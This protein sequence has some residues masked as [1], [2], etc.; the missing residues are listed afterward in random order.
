MGT[1]KTREH[2]LT[3]IDGARSPASIPRRSPDLILHNGSIVTVDASFTTAS[4]VAVSGGIIT[5]VGSDGDIL[6]TAGPATQ[7]IDLAGKTVLPGINDA[8]L[9]GVNLGLTYP[10][11]CVPLAFPEVQ[12]IAD[13]VARVEQAAKS[14][15]PGQW[16][17]GRGWDTAYLREC[18]ETNREPSRHDL[19][20]VSPDHPVYL[21]DFSGHAAWVNTLALK[22]ANVDST[23]VP[24]VGGVIEHDAAGHPTGILREAA[25]VLVRDARPAPDSRQLA[26]AVRTALE[27][28]RSIGITSYTEPGLDAASIATYSALLESGELTSRVTVLFL[29]TGQASESDRFKRA[30]DGW[31][32]TSETDP[33]KLKLAGVKIFADGI[34][35]NRTAWM[36]EPYVDG[37]CGSLCVPGD[38][39]S[40]REAEL[41]EI[42]RYAHDAGH[43]IGVHVTGDRGIDAVVDSFA[44]AQRENPQTDP[45]HYV[46]HGDFLGA[47]S[48]KILAEHGFG[49][50]MNPTIK[51]TI[52]EAEEAVVGSERAGYEWPYRDALDAGLPVTSG[53]DAPV[54]TPDWRQGIATMLLREGKASGR[55]SGPEQ[56][57]TLAEAIRTYT[58]NPAWQDFAEDWK[59]SIEVGKVADF[60]ILDGD[61]L[62]THPRDIPGLNVVCTVLDGEI[63]YEAADQ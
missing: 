9:H 19:D 12:T 52:A 21:Q 47:R 20:A 35:P 7:V 30:L 2:A 14:T 6:A 56:R 54:T 4:A 44:A 18:V 38:T 13:V 22:A 41:A 16:I 26:Q 29:P 59:G 23:T 8:H 24:R 25:Q 55:V 36:H 40:E 33:R 51:W 49:V 27:R 34:P 5:A 11:H 37:G 42:I 48:M 58:I 57:I 28:L 46:I 60:C 50:N 62:K 61:I 31:N 10:P 63:V 3:G 32:K 39:D 43:Q 17:F 15:P 45:R 53:S 1:K